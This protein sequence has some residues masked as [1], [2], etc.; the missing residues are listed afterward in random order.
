MTEQDFINWDPEKYYTYVARPSKY[1]TASGGEVVL[2][3]L[4]IKYFLLGIMEGH[5]DCWRA[6]RLNDV[7]KKG[8]L[9]AKEPADGTIP[10]YIIGATVSDYSSERTV[11]WFDD[12]L[13]NLETRIVEH[14]GSLDWAR[15]TA[16][17]PKSD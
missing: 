17:D 5:P 10:R 7:R 1:R 3:R 14:I 15:E 16:D 12:D 4:D 6:D 11:C 9:I 2:C 13:G 8:W